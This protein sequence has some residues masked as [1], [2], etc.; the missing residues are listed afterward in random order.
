M[1][2]TWLGQELT[3]LAFLWRLE[4]RDGVTLGFTSHDKDITLGGLIYRATPGMLPSAIVRTDGFDADTVE[5]AGALTSDALTQAD[6]QAGRWD[7]ASLWLSAVDWTNAVLDPVALVRGELGAIEINDGRFN[8][9]LRGPTSLLDAPVVEETQPECRASLGDK[10]CRVDLAPLRVDTTVMSASG[11]AITLAGTAA[12]GV[13]AFGR[14]RWID[15]KNGG[16]INQIIASAGAVVTL[17]EPAA[18]VPVA[19]TRV[20]LTQGCDRRFAT[21]TGRFANAANFRGE[22]Q[23]PGNDLLT[24]YAT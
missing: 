24:R 1:M 7:G 8:A 10:R 15:G 19:G 17:R 2:P 9:E 4:R 16:L 3:N 23:L 20:E 11:A 6:L 12:D 14:L 21:C 18:F 5:L 13:Y 22:P